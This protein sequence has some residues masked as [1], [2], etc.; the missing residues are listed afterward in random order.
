MFVVPKLVPM[1]RVRVRPGTTAPVPSWASTVTAGTMASSTATS[2]GWTVNEST[3]ASA[4][5]SAWTAVW[6]GLV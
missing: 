4:S 1:A 6:G 2:V 5:V 3:G